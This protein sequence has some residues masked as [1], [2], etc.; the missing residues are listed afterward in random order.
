MPPR[1]ISLVNATSDGQATPLGDVMKSDLDG[2]P[3]LSAE[4]TAENASRRPFGP[5]L[6]IIT[7]GRFQQR[8]AYLVT[9]IVISAAAVL[10]FITVFL[11][12]SPAKPLS[13][14]HPTSNNQGTNAATPVLA[15][16]A[17]TATV[18]AQRTAQPTQSGGT[19]TVGATPATTAQATG[20][21]GSTPTTTSAPTATPKPAPTATPKPPPTATACFD[22]P[23][24][25]NCNNVDPTTGNPNC[26]SPAY[27]QETT[28][29]SSGNYFNNWWNS[30]CQ[31]NWTQ[32][33]ASGGSTFLYQVEIEA[34]P[35]NPSYCDG[36]SSACDNAAY[37]LIYTVS[38]QRNWYTNL[39]YSP[40]GTSARSCAR[41][42][43]NGSAGGWHCGG[44]H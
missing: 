5:Q 12:L 16:N 41:Y 27:I 31:S 30:T 20:T 6:D 19:G 11:L 28:T 17:A 15:V 44:W 38:N 33:F 24:A 8:H 4:R 26:L 23:S 40:G 18:L 7:G 9:L 42:K 3:T 35:H 14:F 34:A 43:V 21:A 1:S 39:V 22:H 13:A 2:T 29:V 32:A 10:I 36:N 37:K 25:A